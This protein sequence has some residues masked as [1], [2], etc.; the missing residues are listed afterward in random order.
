MCR[1]DN[2]KL[3]IAAGIALR[4]DTLEM[5]VTK[6]K[7]KVKREGG[8]QTEMSLRNRATGLNLAHSAPKPAQK[9]QRWWGSGLSLHDC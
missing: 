8:L 4:V 6:L 5:D 1:G 3:P 9:L 7:Q 2:G